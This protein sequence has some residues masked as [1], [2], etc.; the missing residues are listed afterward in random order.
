MHVETAFCNE[1]VSLLF[2]DDVKSS[3]NI[4]FFCTQYLQQHR[5][6]LRLQT[7]GRKRTV[8]TRFTTNNS[9]FQL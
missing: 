8:N 4:E 3:T 5:Y 7:F 6:L 1:T 9:F 2:Q